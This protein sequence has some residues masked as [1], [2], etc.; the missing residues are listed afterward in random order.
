MFYYLGLRDALQR[1][2]EDPILSEHLRLP[3]VTEPPSERVGHG[4]T[5]HNVWESEGWYQQV[6]CGKEREGVETTQPNFGTENNRRNIVLSL[7]VDGFQA[8]KRVGYS[9]TPLVCMILNLPENLRHQ[10]SYMPLVGLIPGPKAPKHLNPYLE[11]FCEELREL[12]KDGMQIKDPTLAHLPE[13]EQFITVR[14]KLLFT[15]LDYP[16]H[17]ELT[18]QQ[19][20]SATN[21]CVKC[22]IQVRKRKQKT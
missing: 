2:L 21:G 12:Y 19:G 10:A 6:V 15:C 17:G 11:M 13:D 9:M 22:S 3:L 7:N 1:M 14:V 5:V 20:A 8:Y 16:A 4:A 18:N